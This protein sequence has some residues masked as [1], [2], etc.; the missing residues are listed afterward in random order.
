MEKEDKE[1]ITGAAEPVGERMNPKEHVRRYEELKVSA[2]EYSKR[3]GISRSTFYGWREKYGK[4]KRGESFKLVGEFVEVKELKVEKF[5]EV[6]FSGGIKV[7]VERASDKL[8]LKM[9]KEVYGI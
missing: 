5:V 3:A 1:V 4:S 7:K 6:E 2:N 9:L 8:V